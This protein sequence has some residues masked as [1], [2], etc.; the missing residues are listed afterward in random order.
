MKK[1]SKKK[2][3]KGQPYADVPP[4]GRAFE[5]IQQDR[6]ARGLGELPGPEKKEGPVK[7]R[8]KA[9]RRS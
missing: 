1:P 8:K 5:R 7:T 2:P 9:A 6:L 3:K 4:S